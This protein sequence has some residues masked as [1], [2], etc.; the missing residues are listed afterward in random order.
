MSCE[1]WRWMGAQYAMTPLAAAMALPSAHGFATDV[2]AHMQPGG[3]ILSTPDYFLLARPVHFPGWFRN[4]FWNPAHIWQKHR[5]ALTNPFSRWPHSECN[6]W[7][8]GVLAGDMVTAYRHLMHV[9]G[10]FPFICW[11]TRKNEYRWKKS[12]PAFD[13]FLQNVQRLQQQFR[14]HQAP[15]REPDGVE[16]TE[17]ANA[18]VA[19]IAG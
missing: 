12:G 14:R 3:F 10:E 4:D 18:G 8:I 2:L 7:A 6:A 17:P 5:D 13:H 15:A 19:A 9:G 11:Q 1:G 16:N